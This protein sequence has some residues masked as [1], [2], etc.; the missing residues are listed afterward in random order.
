MDITKTIK[1]TV[2]KVTKDPKILEKFQKD[3]VKTVESVVGVD[4]PDDVINQVVDAVKAKVS[5][6]KAG[7]LLGSLTKGFGK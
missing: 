2:D 4:L 7:D 6:D 3:P 1:E 5:F